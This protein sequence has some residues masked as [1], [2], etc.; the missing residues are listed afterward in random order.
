MPDPENLHDHLV[1]QLNFL[2]N[3]DDKL[4]WNR[5]Q[6]ESKYHNLRESDPRNW[7]LNINPNWIIPLELPD[8]IADTQPHRDFAIEDGWAVIGGKICVESNQYEDYALHLSFLASEDEEIRGDSSY[9]PCCWEAR[10][11]N[12]KYRVAKQYHFD[13]DPGRNENEP[14]P[15]THFQSD[16]SFEQERL[17]S[18]LQSEGIH[19][20]SSPLDKPRLAH[21]P[22]DPILL[23]QIISEQYGGPESMF[24]EHWD[25]MVIKAESMLWAGYYGGIAEHLEDAGRSVPCNTLVSNSR[26]E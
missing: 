25:P 26:I 18:N 19:Y 4:S 22:M 2:R 14:K 6:F 13:I 5:G 21:P 8:Y 23:F 16:G 9:G 1:S 11:E 15:A 17:P 20:C 12:W 3:R 7:F 24:S 10:Q